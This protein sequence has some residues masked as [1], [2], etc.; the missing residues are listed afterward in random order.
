MYCSFSAFRTI[1]DR[2]ILLSSFVV[3]M[4]QKEEADETKR[5]KEYNQMQ[6]KK[7]H[8]EYVDQITES[9]VNPFGRILLFPSYSVGP[10]FCRLCDVSNISY[11]FSP[12]LL[13]QAHYQIS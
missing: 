3:K 12:A 1:T 4:A 9:N 2:R 10:V 6:K 5:L 11:S 7:E 8:Q 13:S